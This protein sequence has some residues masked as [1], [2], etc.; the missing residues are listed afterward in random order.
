MTFL[1]ANSDDLNWIGPLK[2]FPRWQQHFYFGIHTPQ[3]KRG[4]NLK[5]LAKPASV[6]KLVTAF[7][8]MEKLTPFYV[9]QTKI[10][11]TDDLGAGLQL[12]VKGGA[13][14]LLLWEKMFLMTNKLKNWP[15][16]DV[17]ILILDE[18]NFNGKYVP[19]SRPNLRVSRP[20]DTP[21]SSL[22]FNW[23]TVE[24]FI[25]SGSAKNQFLVSLFPFDDMWVRKNI[26]VKS[27]Q[28]NVVRAKV[29]KELNGWS[30]EG[31]A[32][33]APSSTVT[34]YAPVGDPPSWFG[35]NL[36]RFLKLLGFINKDLSIKVVKN[37]QVPACK[38]QLDWVSEPLV[39]WVE[40]MNKFSNNFLAEMITM[41]LGYQKNQI[42]DLSFSMQS[43][44]EFLKAK[45]YQEGADFEIHN[46]AGFS[47]EN[48]V[49]PDF[50][51]SILHNWINSRWRY[52]LIQSLPVGGFDGTLK[53]RFVNS[54]IQVRA[55]TGLLN[56]VV[57][58]A[59][60]LIVNSKEY[61][62]VVIYNG[63]NIFHARKIID[64]WVVYVGEKI[65]QLAT[66]L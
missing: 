45:G 54:S 15:L 28:D 26:R 32:L 27:S 13:D 4:W 36:G 18:S 7:V 40:G 51:L 60:F 37:I 33:V 48:K 62:F 57:A 22:S 21:I 1:M 23:N 53:N 2:D 6:T 47:H 8:A 56:D 17:N 61:P 9:T 44:L 52:E 63:S 65:S 10:C 59:G 3:G 58:L 50:I 24:I 64:Q 25:Q 39:K 38:Y 43:Y 35:H 16:K 49:T 14:P 5:S 41:H 19:S 29:T 20:Y 30:I 12:Y 66:Q 11:L 34:G 42:F 31:D 55:K 46:P